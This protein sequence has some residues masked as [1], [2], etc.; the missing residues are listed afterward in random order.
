M[1]AGAV[2]WDFIEA[3]P[4]Q[5][6]GLD[7]RGPLKVTK[8]NSQDREVVPDQEMVDYLMRYADTHLTEPTGTKPS[9]RPV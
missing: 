5:K 7:L 2:D 8:R 3:Y 6:V 4:M 1:V 9:C